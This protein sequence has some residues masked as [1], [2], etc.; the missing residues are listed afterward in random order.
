MTA[1]PTTTAYQGDTVTLDFLLLADNGSPEDLDD[2]TLVWALADP[3]E[4]DVPI[5]QKTVG[6]GITLTSPATGR[7]QV[8]ISAGDLDTPGT[9]IHEIEG[10]TGA[11]ATYTY[12]QGLLIVKATVLPA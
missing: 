8:T 12:G 6:S 10:T 11:G 3:D 4:I 9:Y 7:C 5:L 1:L 2:L